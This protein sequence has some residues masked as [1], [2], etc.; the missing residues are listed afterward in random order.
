MPTGFIIDKVDFGNAP[1]STQNF[2]FYYKLWSDPNSAYI[3]ITASV[4]V[5]VDGTV[6]AS[7]PLEV[8][9]LVA[10]QLYYLKGANNCDSPVDFFVKQIQL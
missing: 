2:S 1:A 3:I 4:P 7:P 10:G 6:M 8:T 9:G 5:L